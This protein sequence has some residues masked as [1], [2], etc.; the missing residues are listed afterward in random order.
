MF[1]EKGPFVQMLKPGVGLHFVY[2]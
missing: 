2:N 1:H